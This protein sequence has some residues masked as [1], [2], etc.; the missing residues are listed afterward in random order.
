MFAT[1]SSSYGTGDLESTINKWE[2]LLNTSTRMQVINELKKESFKEDVKRCADAIIS[3]L[4][5]SSNVTL[6]EY[7]IT[8][9]KDLLTRLQ[10]THEKIS[11][12]V[13]YNPEI[14]NLIRMAKTAHAWMLTKFSW[15][16]EQN[17]LVSEM[18][19]FHISPFMRIEAHQNLSYTQTAAVDEIKTC[20]QNFK[21][22][23]E[24]L[25]Q[26]LVKNTLE[27]DLPPLY[28]KFVE[29]GSA[30]DMLNLYHI[31]PDCKLDALIIRKYLEILHFP[32]VIIKHPTF[33]LPTF[34]TATKEIFEK[35]GKDP[36][37]KSRENE[38]LYRAM[39]NEYH[40]FLRGYGYEM[41]KDESPQTYL[42]RPSSASP[43]YKED[44]M[45]E[46]KQEL[47]HVPVSVSYVKRS[48]NSQLNRM[49]DEVLNCVFYV[50]VKTGGFVGTHDGLPAR[51]KE[52]FFGEMDSFD[53]FFSK[54]AGVQ[55]KYPLD[56]NRKKPD[57]HIPYRSS[58]TPQETPKARSI[59][60]SYI[61]VFVN[62]QGN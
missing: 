41:L 5:S 52:D 45:D 37:A 56:L 18:T 59:A 36:Y 9:M 6:D 53:D 16:K 17:T 27:Q 62:G 46:D 44:A 55:L 31:P 60:R 51:S 1:Y 38:D 24:V 2:N 54:Q 4:K 25:E 22:L 10:A 19:N 15:E 29:L 61:R 3:N 21:N 48:Y 7:K 30:L 13:N 35:F 39:Q 11:H 42:I 14:E 50:N 28:D 34:L 33:H 20:I 47:T 43:L 58:T 49:N 57:T 40:Q 32:K 8:T 23:R 26:L 12:T